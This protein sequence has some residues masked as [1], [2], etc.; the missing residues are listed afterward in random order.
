ML[1][2][3]P[4]SAAE[5]AAGRSLPDVVLARPSS[6]GEKRLVFGP[7]AFRLSPSCEVFSWLAATTL[8][9]RLRGRRVLE[10][11]SGLGLTG[12]ALAIWCECASVRLSDGDPQAVERLQQNVQLN[13]GNFGET[14]VDAVE[15]LWGEGKLTDLGERFDVIIAS[16]CVYDRW[17][18]APLLKTL[19]RW[20]SPRGCVVVIASRRCGS[21][22]DFERAAHAGFCVSRWPAH[23]DEAVS[24][25][26]RSVK[27]FPSVLTLTRA[28][29][30]ARVNNAP[31]AVW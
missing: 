10:L 7:F 25:R 11:G 31:G 16:D 29:A 4:P 8:R 20:L 1:R 24:A 13:A 27:C 3:H 22:A 5:E 17:L 26:F 30:A 6:A 21:L 12:L 18:H 19:A 15:L 28:P 14:A 2:V 9:S 23:Y